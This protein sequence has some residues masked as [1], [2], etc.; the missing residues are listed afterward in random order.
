MQLAATMM[1][2]SVGSTM[3]RDATKQRRKN[4]DKK[5]EP[6][7]GQ[8]EWKIVEEMNMKEKGFGLSVQNVKNYER[9]KDCSTARLGQ[10][11]NTWL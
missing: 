11:Q 8:L 7:Y 6:K 5:Q 9:N 4:G 3:M 10:H 1:N 2:A